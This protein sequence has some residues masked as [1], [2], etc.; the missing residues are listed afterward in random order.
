MDR[1]L[2]ILG[3]ALLFGMAA[4]LTLGPSPEFEMSTGEDSKMYGA[5]FLGLILLVALV[6]GP[7]LR[8]WF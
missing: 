5:A 7:D 3:F 4:F 2:L 1:R 8:D 6:L